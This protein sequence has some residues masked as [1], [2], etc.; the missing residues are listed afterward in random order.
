MER[1]DGKKDQYGKAV[2]KDTLYFTFNAD[3]DETELI[4]TLYSTKNSFDVK[5]KGTTDESNRKY[6]DKGGKNGANFFVDDILSKLI[7]QLDKNEVEKAKSHWIEMARKGLEIEFSKQRD[8]KNNINS[9]ILRG[10]K[11][12]DCKKLIGKKSFIQ[13]IN[14]K[15]CHLEECIKAIK[16]IN[17]NRMLLYTSGTENI[18]VMTVLK[19]LMLSCLKL[20]KTKYCQLPM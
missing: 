12:S 14:C 19:C 5:V 18:F 7:N 15:K 10:S 13:C 8:L 20:T 6:V 3:D 9:K 1:I 16:S 4:I 11:C 2:V 17:K